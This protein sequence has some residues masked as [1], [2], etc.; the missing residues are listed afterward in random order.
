MKLDSAKFIT[1]IDLGGTKIALANIGEQGEIKR[2]KQTIDASL[3]KQD[4]N[5]FLV[6]SI[7]E[8]ATE[9]CQGISIGV[10]GLVDTTTGY[11]I[12]VLN[13]PDWQ[14]V[15]LKAILEETFNLPVL[16]HN[17]ANCFTYGIYKQTDYKDN[18]NLIGIT[19]GTGLGAGLILN[20]QLYTGNQSAAGEF[21]S[22][23][24]LDGIIEQY[25]SGQFFKRSNMDGA[26]TYQQAQ[27]GD[28]QAVAKF[29]ELGEHLSHAVTQIIQAFNPET[30][31][32]GGS[33]AK[34]YP[35]FINSLQQNL[36]QLVPSSVFNALQINYTQ[37]TQTA[38]FGAYHLFLDEV[39]SCE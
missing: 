8:F 7:A 33:V 3:S 24:Y 27:L 20:G 32:F 17:D 23:P 18:R 39:L 34:S 13:I 14:E 16:I 37:D 30:I 15:E 38:L 31:V 12:E 35:L 19:L 22:F 2:S 26:H 5:A 10:P 36:T 11:V 6:S 21:G 1:C 28:S 25:C 9:G 29:N 4:F